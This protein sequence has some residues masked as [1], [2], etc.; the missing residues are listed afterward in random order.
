MGAPKLDQHETLHGTLSVYGYTNYRV[1]LRD[2]YQFR[3]ESTRGYSFRAFSK[4]AGLSSPNYLKLVINGDRNIS[5]PMTEKFIKA[6]SLKAHQAEYFRALV[7]LNQART[8]EAKQDHL[9]TLEKLTPNSK[10][11]L[12]E[13]DGLKYLS[14][15]LYPVIREMTLLPDFSEDPH[16]ISRR[17]QHPVPMQEIVKA[18]SFLKAE[19]YIAQRDDGTWDTP[20][21]MV[22][23]SDE[24]K[25]L[26]IRNY[27]R[28]QAGLISHVMDAVDVHDRELG[29]LTLIL[30]ESAMEE[31]KFKLKAFRQDIHKWAVHSL[32]DET[33]D[34]V[35][36]LNF[37]MFP[38]TKKRG[39]PS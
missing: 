24:I 21:D 23:S 37:Q 6:L 15:W 17:L 5:G 19:G 33:C 16:W 39:A 22:I 10:R 35:I 29:A 18:V 2:F 1:Y 7:Q 14:H 9:K 34:T 26:A 4:A 20:T 28:T 32:K 12:L 27:H 30:P 31:L 3:K 11:D 8:D 38:H 36:Q 25:S 13:T